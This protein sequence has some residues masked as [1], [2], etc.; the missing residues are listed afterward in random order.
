MRR[1]SKI[2]MCDVGY[3]PGTGRMNGMGLAMF[4]YDGVIVDSFNQVARDF[5]EACRANGFYGINTKED[6]AVLHEGNCYEQMMRLGLPEWKVDKIIM[7]YEVIAGRHIE[8]V[9]VFE[10]MAEALREI[11]RWN[12]IVIITSNISGQVRKVLGKYGISCVEDIIGAEIEKSKIKKIRKAMQLYP[13]FPAYYIGDTAGDI[14]E[15][16]EAGA[17]TVGVT[18]GWHDREKLE[19]LS[20]DY[21]VSTPQE[22]AVVLCNSPAREPNNERRD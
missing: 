21:L 15:G 17:L 5:A 11:A 14:I 6:L 19:S 4:D 3:H 1:I 8:D 10:G 12:R 13:G 2:G 18:W 22:L 16:R 20:P 9:P 7:D